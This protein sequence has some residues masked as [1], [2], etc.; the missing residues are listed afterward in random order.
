MKTDLVKIVGVSAA[1]KSTLAAGLR[2]LGYNARPVAQEHSE[3]PDMWQ[4]IRPPAWL[5]FLDA[6]LPSQGARRPDVK[7]SEPWRRTE[8][9]RLEHARGHADLLI[10]T[11]SL[12]AEG[13]LQ[14]AVNFLGVNGVQP[15][16]GPLAALPRTGGVWRQS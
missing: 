14:R 12:T 1:G 11:S 9:E 16:P 8:L 4:R 5:V 10:D 7:W 6:D 3:V 15:A 2:R 13:V